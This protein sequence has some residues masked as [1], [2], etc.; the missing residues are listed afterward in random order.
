MRAT[1]VPAQT[2]VPIVPTVVIEEVTMPAGNVVPV[3]PE[4]GTAAAVIEVL[5]PKPVLVV[6]ISASPA[7][8]QPET[9]C[10]VGDADPAVALTRTV[11]VPC[12]ARSASVIR[13]VAV[14][15][16]V[17]VGL[18]IDGA[19][20]KATSPKL[21]VVPIFPSVPPLLYRI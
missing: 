15:A 21:P 10:A 16:V 12:V 1:L 11:F 19:C 5:H 7:A 2:P 20:D 4:A 18:S 3:I 13:P 17:N 6:Q 8:E 9:L 14:T